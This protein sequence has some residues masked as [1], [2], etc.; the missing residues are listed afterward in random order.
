M[1]VG[2]VVGVVIG[3]YQ[4]DEVGGCCWCLNIAF[5]S[6]RVLIPNS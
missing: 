5:M 1:N 2:D 3:L 6:P 4:V